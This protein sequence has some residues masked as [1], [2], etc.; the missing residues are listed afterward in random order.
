MWQRFLCL[1]VNFVRSAGAADLGKRA[2]DL[3]RLSDK[4]AY[5]G[6]EFLKP[7]VGLAANLALLAWFNPAFGLS[8]TAIVALY[9]ACRMRRGKDADALAEDLR[10]IE[11]RNLRLLQGIVADLAQ[12]RLAGALNRC[13]SMWE[14][15][16]SNQCKISSRL[17]RFRQFDLVLDAGLLPLSLF[18]LFS[19]HATGLLQIHTAQVLASIIAL[20]LA[21]GSAWSL[22]EYSLGLRRNKGAGRRLSEI[23][24]AKVEA[25]TRPV[26]EPVIRGAI[27]V[28]AAGFKYPGAAAPALNDVSLRIEAGEFVGLAG[29]SGSGKSTLIRLLLGFESAYGG[30]ILFDGISSRDVPMMQIRRQMDAVLQDESLVPGTIRS[31]IVGMFDFREEEAWA[32]ARVAQLADEIAA[33]PMG[34]Q[35]FASDRVLSTSQ[36]QRLL[37]ARAVVRRPKI[38]IL[39][40]AMS[41]L[42]EAMQT[43]L[44]NALRHWAAGTAGMTCVI[45]SH[46]PSLLAQMDRVFVFEHGALVDT[47]KGC[48][49]AGDSGV[50]AFSN[51]GRIASPIPFRTE[52]VERLASP[53]AM[54]QLPRLVC[55]GPAWGLLALGIAAAGA[56]AYLLGR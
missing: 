24:G 26:A 17:R 37:I 23:L 38:L 55:A 29:P 28:E 25:G 16:F 22:S 2:A 9:F 19:M 44:L 4:I 46:R 40:E 27:A 50:A 12:L 14:Q 56:G 30:T 49:D 52:A 7:A 31:N 53:Q 39:D 34:M 48:H 21:L 10:G 47:R 3:R 45:V 11:Q 15:A 18:L 1:P 41:A 32:A 5:E 51:A 42:D 35:T 36:R 13:G 43:R 33:M 54:D 20:G 6:V 8:A